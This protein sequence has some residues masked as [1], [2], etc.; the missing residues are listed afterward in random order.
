MASLVDR[1]GAR[2]LQNRRCVRAPIWLYR[3]GL[4]WL[5]GGRVLMLEHIGRRSGRPRYV[6]LEV[7]SRP[8]PDVIVVV[9]GFGERAQWYRNLRANGSCAVSIGR[10]RRVPAQARLMDAAESAAILQEYQR[11]HPQAWRRL[12]SVIE[13]AVSGQVTELPMVELGLDR[14]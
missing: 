13:E 2:L 7:V 8:D 5:L 3:H 9:S 10:A 12:R 1:V 14:R 4:G 6:C 11:A